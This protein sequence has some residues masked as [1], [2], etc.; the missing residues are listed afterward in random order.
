[1]KYITNIL[2]LITYSPKMAWNQHKK[3]ALLGMLII[4]T[5]FLDRI[6]LTLSLPT[7]HQ[8]SIIFKRTDIKIASLIY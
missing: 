5:Y 3:L 4:K 7:V 8:T 2:I 1:M 6:M